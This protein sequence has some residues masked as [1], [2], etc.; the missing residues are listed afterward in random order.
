[1][2][3]LLF[4]LVGG[5]NDFER[6]TVREFV[7][8]LGGAY[9]WPVDPPAFVN[10]T[11]SSSCT[12]P[13][14]VPVRTVGGSLAFHRPERPMNDGLDRA[15]LGACEHLL[16]CLKTFSSRTGL[17]VG[18]EFDGESLGTIERGSIPRAVDE[19]LLRPWRERH[20]GSPDGL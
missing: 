3:T 7:D 12:A 15:D 6:E 5:V 18:I 8:S 20:G 2:Q 1:M 17:S 10:S 11:D 4:Y 9:E 16:Q 19:G 13:C 14:D